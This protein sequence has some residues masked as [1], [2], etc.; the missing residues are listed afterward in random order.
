MPDTGETP[1]RGRDHQDEARERL[2]LARKWAYLLVSRVFVPLSQQDLERELL[3]ILDAVHAVVAGEPSDARPA[4]EA[5]VRLVELGYSAV[6]VLPCTMD[7]LG[8]GLLSLPEFRPV[9][10]FAERVVLALGALAHGFSTA[11]RQKVLD[12]QEDMSLSMLKAVRDARWHLAESE[13]RFDEVA[14][15]SASGIMI[16]DVAGRLVRVNAAIADMLGYSVTELTG[17]DLFDLVHPSYAQ[18]LRE[19]HA[20]LLDG[21]K[22]RVRQS[23]VLV[24]RNG[25]LARVALTATLLRGEDD[26]PSQFVTVVEDGTE[27]LLLRGE[28]NRQAL[29]D[30]LTGLPNRQYFGT[31]VEKTLRKADATHGIT[32][33]HLDLDSFALICN[34]LGR[35]VGDRLLVAAARRLTA[36][37]AD[38]NAIVARLGSDEFAILVENSATTPSVATIVARVNEELST[39]VDAD[40]RG[41]AMSASIGVV[42]RPEPRMEAAELLRAADV[43][44]RKAKA[45]GR[46]Q[47][48]LFHPDQDERDRD[49][50][51]LAAQLPGAF[52]GGEFSVGYRPLARLADGRIDGVTALPNWQRAGSPSLDGRR[53]A[54]LADM[55][56]LTLRLGDWLLRDAS[57]DTRWWR[58]RFAGELSLLVGLTAHQSSDADLVSRVVGALDETGLPPERLTLLLP[59]PA[60]SVPEVADNLRVLAD[61]GVR[62]G[63][64]EFGTAPAE[65]ALVEDLPVRSVRLAHR[66][67][68]RAGGESLSAGALRAVLPLVREADVSVMVDGVDTRAAAD[69]WLSI[70]ADVG[71]GDLFG[72]Q[73]S[74]TD[75]AGVL[76]T[77]ND[78]S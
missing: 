34:G 3:D 19:D 78:M 66:L 51:T 42:H 13:A 39:P 75:I 21:T 29:H 28:L 72:A 11:G 49:T 33:F 70:G 45:A 6:E 52:E 1:D 22:D 37:V 69:W 50:Y 26:R 60:F 64:D 36:V 9:E 15:S 48:S 38:E 53:C 2:V 16:T 20:A 7:V 10:R 44:L 24:C 4:Y 8:K 58:Q 77:A 31:L 47:W 56:G 74:A 67:V 35:H 71:T 40:G 59:A 55:T 43:T 41:V 63:L 23:Q 65:L 5:G 61:V 76:A 17:R 32:L 54:E 25:D 62:T 30:A 46:A 68:S 12:Q 57:R 73:C 18:V 27:L 14:T